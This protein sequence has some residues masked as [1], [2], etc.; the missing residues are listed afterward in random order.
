MKKNFS[1]IR[2]LEGSAL[3]NRER[4]YACYAFINM[5]GWL[6]YMHTSSLTLELV[7]LNMLNNIL[8]FLVCRPEI[9]HR[10]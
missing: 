6:P 8:M 3:R 5:K 7:S 10:D 2:Y 1:P 4:E 9:S